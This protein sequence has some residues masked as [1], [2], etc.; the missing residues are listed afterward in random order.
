MGSDLDG[1]IQ[2]ALEATEQSEGPMRAAPE[3]FARRFSQSAIGKAKEVVE[4]LQKAAPIFREGRPAFVSIGGADGAEIEHLL[5]HTPSR[6]GVVIEY[7]RQLAELARDRVAKLKEVGVTLIVL[8]GDAKVKIA[9]AVEIAREAVRE[10]QASYVAVT[11]HAILHELYDRGDE[12]FDPVAFFAAMFNDAKI[13]TWLTYREPSVPLEWPERVKITAPCD[14]ATLERLALAMHGRAPSFFGKKPIRT[15]D[16]CVVPR[17][18]AM[19]LIVKLSYL[20]LLA[21]ELGE[22]STAIDFKTLQ[23]QLMT[24]IGVR[25]FFEGRAEVRQTHFPTR[26]FVDNFRRLGLQIYGESN[27]PLSMPTS[28]TRVVASSHPALASD[29]VPAR[30]RPDLLAVARLAL[31]TNNDGLLEA[32]LLSE[33]RSWIETDKK[34]EVVP[35]LND[36]LRARATGSFAYEWSYYLLRLNELFAGRAEPGAFGPE[37]QQAARRCDLDLLFLAEE[38]EALRKSDP[39][40]AIGRANRLVETLEML[41]VGESTSDKDRYAIATCHFLIGNLLRSGGLYR[42][43]LDYIDA[44]AQIYKSGVPSHA[45]ELAHGIYARNVCL[46]MTTGP[47]IPRESAELGAN[48]RKFADGLIALTLSHAAWAAEDVEQASTLTAQARDFFNSV[49]ATKYAQRAQATA[50][51]FDAWR[52]TRVGESIHAPGLHTE[53]IIATLAGQAGAWDEVRDWLATAR[54]SVVLGHLQFAGDQDAILDRVEDF[55]TPRLLVKTDNGFEWSP[56]TRVRTL[57]DVRAQL[58]THVGTVP[59]LRVPLLPD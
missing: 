37:R 11:A 28:Q 14:P 13:P 36:V 12:E 2:R 53:R 27:E 9:E 58:L 49:G 59:E 30:A 33:G 5:V 34:D 15:A 42:E 22:R 35:L 19:E 31:E 29:S 48:G 23:H 17:R 55:Q 18:L 38:M 26:S 6:L 32:I 21:Y 56:E 44:A 47:E 50:V 43:A 40:G 7:N 20:E 3:D 54:P 24:A 16:G 51:L 1:E 41:H 45:T 8:E 57:R 10:G 46:A 4:E 39:P 25:A 52:A